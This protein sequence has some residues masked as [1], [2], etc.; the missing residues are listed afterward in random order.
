[1]KPPD[2][3]YCTSYEYRMVSIK[4]GLVVSKG[5]PLIVQYGGEQIKQVMIC[6]YTYICIVNKPSF[7][8]LS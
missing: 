2:T 7:V 3:S 8:R 6:I 5:R 4:K 1:M